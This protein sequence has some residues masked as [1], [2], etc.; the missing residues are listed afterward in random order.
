MHFGL[1]RVI[2][3]SNTRFADR[4][5]LCRLSFLQVGVSMPQ[6][7]YEYSPYKRCRN[8][9][10]IQQSYVHTHNNIRHTVL[11]ILTIVISLG[12]SGL[13]RNGYLISRGTKW[14]TQNDV[15]GTATRCRVTSL[16]QRSPG[17]A[18]AYRADV[19][20]SRMRIP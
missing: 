2:C 15:G 11:S 7:P 16:R 17:I 6:T 13:D 8:Q 20:S 3:E 18:H 10:F 5:P 4:K 14:G 12:L 1:Q 19:M 9:T